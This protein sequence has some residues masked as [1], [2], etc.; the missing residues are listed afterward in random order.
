MCFSTPDSQCSTPSRVTDTPSSLQAFCHHH[1]LFWSHRVKDKGRHF[2]E[3]WWLLVRWVFRV[4]RRLCASTGDC[5]SSVCVWMCVCECVCSV[6]TCKTCGP[7]IAW[8]PSC[9]GL[10]GGAES[11]G[12]FGGCPC[13]KLCW[14]WRNR[15]TRMKFWELPL[16]PEGDRSP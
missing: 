6:H 11:E 14:A 1:L 16:G 4:Y 15:K 13:L 2:S 5:K 12:P 3:A 8:C 7:Y 9:P 10:K